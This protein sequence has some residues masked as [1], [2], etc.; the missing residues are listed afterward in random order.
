MV[1][2]FHVH[3]FPD[4]LA[5]K[6]IQLLEERAGIHAKLNGTVAD[7]KSSM[8]RAGID[9]SVVLPIATKPSH[10]ESI[11]TWS[12]SIQDSGII[13]F[14]SIHPDY[15]GWKNELGRIKS[16][17]LKG[18]KFHPEYQLFY[19]DEPKLFPLYEKALDLGLVILFH[20]GVD[21]GLPG[22]YHCTPERLLKVIKAFPGGK[23]VA[24]HM[25]SYSYWHDVEKFLVGEDVYFD[26][27]YSLG[28]MDD[29]QAKRIINRHGYKKILFG[30]DSPWKDQSEQL[31]KV[32]G[33]GLDREAE[34]AILGENARRL[35]NDVI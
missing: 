4:E 16:L 31:T 35:L 34:D 25:G 14:G 12:A 32:K 26:T 13:A 30:T 6:A 15:A 19:V 2:D 33:L 11:N 9:I 27:S 17:G 20:A 3:C 8:E 7:L 28:I 1:I 29:E 5:A 24:S 10:T 21:I 22:P 18:L 23:I